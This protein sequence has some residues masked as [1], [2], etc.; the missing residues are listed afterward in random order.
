MKTQIWLWTWGPLRLRHVAY[1][2][3]IT[4]NVVLFTLNNTWLFKVNIPR[5]AISTV[6]TFTFRFEFPFKLSSLSLYIC[7]RDQIK[8]KSFC[9]TNHENRGFYCFIQL[10]LM[11]LFN[12]LLILMKFVFLFWWNCLIKMIMSIIK[13]FTINITN[14]LS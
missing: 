6:L 4:L 12:V 14:Q 10:F 2:L 9:T 3:W 11:K 5:D 1:S 7:G 13:V 8:T